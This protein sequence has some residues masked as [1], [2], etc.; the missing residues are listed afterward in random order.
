[1]GRN[2]AATPGSSAKPSAGGRSV[3]LEDP[4]NGGENL[5]G[6]AD[7]CETRERRFEGK[8]V[9]FRV[10]A[11]ASVLDKHKGKA[12]ASALAR[13]GLDACVRGDTGEDN[14]VD[15]TG[16]ELLLQVGA[17]EGA[18]VALGDENVPR[19]ETGG[20]SD[21]SRDSGYWLVAQ[22][23]RLVGGML[24]KV[25]DIDGHIDNRSSGGTEGFGKLF[26]VCDDLHSGIRGGV[27][28]ENR[29]IQI[30]EDECGLFGVELK[31]RHEFLRW[32]KLVYKSRVASSTL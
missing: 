4:G 12:E 3:S 24:Q 13:G 15:A 31:F 5:V 29:I 17:S 19:L 10:L 14:G 22:V 28:A 2:R 26:G 18:P 7:A 23:I 27:Q 21:L 11:C 16:L 6:R 20:R 8:T 32:E 30:N 25:V 9:V 1:M